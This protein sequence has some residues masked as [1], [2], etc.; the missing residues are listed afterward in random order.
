VGARKVGELTADGAN[1]RRGYW[2]AEQESEGIFRD[3][4]IYQAKEKLV[5]HTKDSLPR[6]SGVI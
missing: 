1:V 4:E 3:G 5:L 2:R 6:M